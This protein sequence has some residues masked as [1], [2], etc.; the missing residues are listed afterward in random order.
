MSK[1]HKALNT[2][3]RV[4]I[5]TRPD[6]RTHGGIILPQYDMSREEGILEDMGS[7]AFE[8][9]GKDRPKVGDKVVFARYAGKDLGTYEDGMDR[10]LMRDLD[11]LAIV[12]ENN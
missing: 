7:N 8:D 11:V 3:V 6:D 2:N 10:R 1:V 12:V 5:I 9:F 4:K